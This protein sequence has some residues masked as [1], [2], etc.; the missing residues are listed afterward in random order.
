MAA[1]HEIVLVVTQPDRGRRR[2]KRG[3]PSAVK[4]EAEALGLDIASP[5]R[6]AELLPVLKERSPDIAAV[7]AFG[8]LLPAE[9]IGAFPLGMVNVHFSLLPRWRGAA[10]VERAILA[11]DRESGVTT[12]MIDAGLDTGPVCAE[13][14]VL[15]GPEESAGQL[16]E[17][18]AAVGAD[19]L[20]ETLEKMAR[21]EID[22]VPQDDEASSYATKLE[23]GE[24]RINWDSTT[25]DISRLVRA[26]SP[27]PGA[28]TSF[29]GARLKVLRVS[30]VGENAERS[31]QHPGEVVI[32]SERF[33]VGT[34]DGVLELIEVQQEGKGVVSGGDFARGARFLDGARLGE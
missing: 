30:T 29:H 2:N 18:L 25:L 1:S 6:A 16:T 24:C 8:Q 34:S 26:A 21:G 7:V 32:A 27:K 28:H 3:F 13:R 12:M 4:Q 15:I 10:P 5:S 31:L 19:L 23:T 33:L 9:V 14:R 20:L 22:P 17:R 11:G